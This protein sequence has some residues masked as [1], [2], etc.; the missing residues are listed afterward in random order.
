[1]G[2]Q[3]NITVTDFPKQGVSAGKRA[4]VCFNYDTDRAFEGV[5]LRDDVEEPFLT[6]IHLDDGRTVLG[7]ECQYQPI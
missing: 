2:T 7:T 4:R 1:M 6:I 5:I 3:K